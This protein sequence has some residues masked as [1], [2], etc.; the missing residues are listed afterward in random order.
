MSSGGRFYRRNNT[1]RYNNNNNNNNNYSRGN[2]GYGG[3]FG[4]N[5]RKQKDCEPFVLSEKPSSGESNRWT[6]NMKS[7]AAVNTSRH[8]HA[9]MLNKEGGTAPELKEIPEKP[10]RV[11]FESEAEFTAAHKEYMTA[12]QRAFTTNKEIGEDSRK[13]HGQMIKYLSEGFKVIMKGQCGSDMI[14]NQ[15]PKALI[16]AIRTQFLG[17]STDKAKNKYDLAILEKEFGDIQQ[18]PRQS[19]AGYREYFDIS[20]RNLAQGKFH[21]QKHKDNARTYEQIL[22]EMCDEE[23][24]ANIFTL[25]LDRRVWGPW[26]LEYHKQHEKWPKTLEAA[27][28]KFSRLE[29][30]YV[31]ALLEKQ[32]DTRDHDDRKVPV[33]AAFAKGDKS[34][35]WEKPRSGGWGKPKPETNSRGWQKPKPEY[36]SHNKQICWYEK[37]HGAGSCRHKADCYFSHDIDHTDG[38]SKGGTIADP[39]QRDPHCGGGPRPGKG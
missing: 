35:G 23:R 22:A 27:Y 12:E 30:H 31:A 33:M 8:N 32:K 26:F 7:W 29:D 28:D 39:K 5:D 6:E 1:A 10:I 17:M 34:K 16:D 37:Q 15:D 4:D 14:D 3:G 13:L 24:L 9:R 21:A 2:A 38:K 20:R 36:D 25:G 19:L 18:R 11:S